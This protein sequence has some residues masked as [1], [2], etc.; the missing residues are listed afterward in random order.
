MHEPCLYSGRI[1]GHRVLLICQVNNFAIAA[2]NSKTVDILLNMIDDKLKIPVK[3]QCYLDMYNSIDVQHTWHYIK[4][5]I[6]S[7]IDKVFVKQLATWMKLAY[8]SPAHST[9]LPS[10]PTFQK[11][12]NSSTGNPDKNSQLKLA[13][14]MQIDYHSGI[15][16]LIWAMM[17]FRPD[18]AYSS[19]KL[20]QSNSCL[21]EVHYHG[22]K[23]ALKYLYHTKDDGLYFWQTE[24]RLELPKGPLPMINSN[25]KDII[26]DGCPQFN[27]TTAHVYTDSDWATCTK[28]RR[29]FGGSCI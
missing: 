12:F 25:R 29:S 11:K 18:L 6:R 15:G 10:D 5:S 28:T 1:N 17:T 14:D 16:E 27:A 3:R 24:P 20:S 9:P 13:K 19:I 4:I 21:Q 23:H 22:L 26:L 7:F 8:P 2:P